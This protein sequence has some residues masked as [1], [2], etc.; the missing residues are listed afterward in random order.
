MEAGRFE[1]GL[2]VETNV[3]GVEESLRFSTHQ[4]S[5]GAGGVA[6][7]EELQRGRGQ[8]GAGLGKG[9]P[10]NGAVVFE[11]LESGFVFLQ[12]VVGEEGVLADARALRAG[13]P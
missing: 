10:I 6:G 12:F 3:A 1:D 5:S 8:T 4:D 2:I 7:V 11:A 9:G 13:G